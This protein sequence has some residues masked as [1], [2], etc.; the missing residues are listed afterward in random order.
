M[1]AIDCPHRRPLLT[2]LL[3][4][5]LL[6]LSVSFIQMIQVRMLLWY[7]NFQCLPLLIGLYASRHIGI[8]FV[9]GLQVLSRRLALVTI[10]SL[11]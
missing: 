3:K 10:V 9:F 4:L 1:A 7:P 5:R 2:D 6:S 8:S 11:P